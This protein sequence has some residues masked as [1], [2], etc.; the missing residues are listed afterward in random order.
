M[1]ESQ[2]KGL[3]TWTEQQAAAQQAGI[4]VTD[5]SQAGTND[6]LHLDC[7]PSGLHSVQ[8]MPAASPNSG[9]DCTAD[10]QPEDGADDSQPEDVWADDS[11]DGSWADDSQLE[12]DWPC[13]NNSQP[14]SAWADESQQKDDYA[15]DLQPEDIHIDELQ[16]KDGYANKQSE[17]NCADDEGDLAPQNWP[18]RE[19]E[20]QPLLLGAMQDYGQW[21]QNVQSELC[22]SLSSDEEG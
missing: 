12:H 16:Q 17:G 18:S 8:V 10:A 5:P 13:L 19:E 1:Q 11:P 2:A 9:D 4:Q 7:A 20:E 14:E 21:E 3:Q 6:W 15:D 22:L